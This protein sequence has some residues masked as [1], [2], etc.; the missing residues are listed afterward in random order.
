MAEHDPTQFTTRSFAMVWNEG[1]SVQLI[2]RD[3]PRQ[4]IS[5][6]WGEVEALRIFLD[7]NLISVTCPDCVEGKITAGCA[8][9]RPSAGLLL[10]Q[11]VENCPV[12]TT[13]RSGHI[14]S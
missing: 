7:T 14:G 1:H 6:P 2:N 10:V 9:D 13:L 12:L 5:I 4:A 11:I 3:D 8:I